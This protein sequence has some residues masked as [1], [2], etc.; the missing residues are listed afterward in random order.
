MPTYQVKIDGEMLDFPGT[1][2][3][4]AERFVADLKRPDS[5][6]IVTVEDETGEEHEIHI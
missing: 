3:E 2:E 4:A 5:Y 6:I 1:P